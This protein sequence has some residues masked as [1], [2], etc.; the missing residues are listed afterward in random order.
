[1]HKL[2]QSKTMHFLKNIHNIT[3]KKRNTLSF[4]KLEFTKRST[5]L[6]ILNYTHK[7]TNGLSFSILN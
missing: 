5:I 2:K 6:T 4:I 1:M 7:I 3:K